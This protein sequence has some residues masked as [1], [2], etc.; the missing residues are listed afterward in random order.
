MYSKAAFIEDHLEAQYEDAERK[1]Y[2][3]NALI[4]ALTNDYD[5]ASMRSIDSERLM[6]IWQDVVERVDMLIVNQDDEWIERKYH[7]LKHDV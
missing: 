5:L 6:E 2:I 4:E 7:L 1:D 3:N